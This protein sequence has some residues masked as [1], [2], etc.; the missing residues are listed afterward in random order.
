M[1]GRQRALQTHGLAQFFEGQVGLPAQQLSHLA[2]RGR[3]HER[4]APG[5]VVAW[6]DL[7]G[8]PALLQELFHHA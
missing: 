4:L 1:D 5:A 6:P 3:N 7:A 2:M 8:V